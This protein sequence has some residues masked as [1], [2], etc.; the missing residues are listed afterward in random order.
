M[1]DPLSDVPEEPS[2]FDAYPEDKKEELKKS[3]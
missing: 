1:I 2:R 3:S